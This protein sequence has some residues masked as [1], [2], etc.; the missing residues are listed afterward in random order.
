M[1]ITILL[2]TL[3]ALA[4]VGWW[5][6]VGAMRLVDRQRAVIDSLEQRCTDLTHMHHSAR[7]RAARNLRHVRTL[8]VAIQYRDSRHRV[9]GHAPSRN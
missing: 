9:Y 8:A 4:V 7:M 2:W 1:N 5:G 3:V 6:W